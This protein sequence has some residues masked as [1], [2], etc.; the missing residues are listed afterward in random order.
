MAVRGAR[1]QRRAAQPWGFDPDEACRYANVGDLTRNR[2]STFGLY[3]M[4]GNVW[5]WTEDCYR[6]SY[7]GAPS[8]G[9]ASCAAAG[10]SVLCCVITQH[11]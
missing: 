10:A 2:V 8:D 9:S 7:A 5:E 6:E 11:D 3:D 1:R 4:M